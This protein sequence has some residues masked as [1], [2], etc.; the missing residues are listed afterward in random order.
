MTFK[1]WYSS[2]E[3]RQQNVFQKH[4]PRP[5]ARDAPPIIQRARANKLVIL[6]EKR[7]GPLRFSKLRTQLKQQKFG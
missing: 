2:R 7:D 5:A 4:D 3:L 1:Y 6:G